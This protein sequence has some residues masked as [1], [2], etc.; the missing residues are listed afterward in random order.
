M[1]VPA[2]DYAAGQ[3]TD[4]HAVNAIADI[5]DAAVSLLDHEEVPPAGYPGPQRV[6]TI[7]FPDDSLTSHPI[8]RFEIERIGDQS[9]VARYQHG[10]RAVRTV[11]VDAPIVER[12]ARA[13]RTVVVGGTGEQTLVLT[14]ET[15]ENDEAV[16]V[17]SRVQF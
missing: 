12:D 2:V 8:D 1:S 5:N 7:T 17:V 6:I 9:S 16:I 15:D 3:N 4:R 13:N 11:F 10:S 14:L